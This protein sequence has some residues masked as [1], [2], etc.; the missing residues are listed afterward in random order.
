MINK[1]LLLLS[2][3]PGIKNS[4][5]HSSAVS[6]ALWEM[7]RS[8]EE[9]YCSYYFLHLKNDPFSL[10]NKNFCVILCLRQDKIF[11]SFWLLFFFSIYNQNFIYM[12]ILFCCDLWHISV[13]EMASERFVHPGVYNCNL[14]CFH[15]AAHVN[16]PARLSHCFLCPL[17]DFYPKGIPGFLGAVIQKQRDVL[18]SGWN[19][20]ILAPVICFP[21]VWYQNFSFCWKIEWWYSTVLASRSR[22]P[23]K[24][25]TVLCQ[26]YRPSCT[27]LDS[28]CRN[29]ESSTRRRLAKSVRSQ[30][31]K[32]TL[33]DV[34]LDQIY[35]L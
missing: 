22:V 29:L 12:W 13:D 34:S 26:L 19:V 4:K 23:C 33:T 27:L 7:P 10:R 2:S 31:R 30:K 9:L 3:V 1:N 20:Q 8:Q 15:A 5:N 11:W 35:T 25:I 14:H 21:E 28:F 18:W 16:I 6:H 32:S 24:A 17:Q